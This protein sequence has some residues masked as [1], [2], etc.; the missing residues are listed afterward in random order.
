M[1]AGPLLLAVLLA[2]LIAALGLPSRASAQGIEERLERLGTE[3][4]RLFLHPITA[5][6]GAGLNS[7][8]F[9]TAA[10]HE[11]LGFDVSVRAMGSLVPAEDERFVPLLP[12]TIQY[13]GRAFDDPYAP[14]AG[15]LESPTA[16]GSGDGVRIVPSGDFREALVAAGEDPDDYAVRF[17]DG[18][19]LPAVPSAL[20]QVSVGIPLGTEVAVR[21]LPTLDLGDDIGEVSLTGF[22]VRHSLDQ[23]LPM[24]EVLRLSVSGGWQRLRAGNYLELRARQAS[25]VS[26]AE[27][28]FFSLYGGVG[29]E[30]SSAEV[31]YRLENPT[32]NPALPADGAR[33]TFEDE[34]ENRTRATT[35]VTFNFPIL[36]LNAEYS[37][38]RYSVASAKLLISVR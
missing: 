22:G 8:F 31:D 2:L 27:L 18:L 19:D 34:G 14:E 32:D 23:W 9:H 37:F 3:N 35:G 12:A 4:A 30:S 24:P 6:L 25:V 28:G 16:V 7:G 36:K 26:G 15:G 33:L 13:E 38:A 21:F 20:A 17:P 1:E 11:P 5:G 29:V 10:V